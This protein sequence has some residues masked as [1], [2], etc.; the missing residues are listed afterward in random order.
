MCVRDAEAVGSSPVTSTSFTHD[1][2]GKKEQAQ[3]L[4]LFLLFQETTL[5]VSS[6]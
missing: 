5:S 3:L 6:I 4:S 2:C 1:I